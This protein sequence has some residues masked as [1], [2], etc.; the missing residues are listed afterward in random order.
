VAIATWTRNVAAA[1]SHTES[2]R[3]RVDKRRLAN[4]VLSGSSP[5]K[6]SGKTVA[7]MERSNPDT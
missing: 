6:I 3:P 1:P 2:G 5:K 4:I 7:T